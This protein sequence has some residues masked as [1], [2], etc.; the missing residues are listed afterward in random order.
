MRWTRQLPI[1]PRPSALTRK[2]PRRIGRGHAYW[3]EGE[4]DKAIS[5]YT[6]AIRLDPKAAKAYVGRGEA[7][8]SKGNFDCAIADCTEAIRLNPRDTAAYD[9]RGMAFARKQEFDKAIADCTE[10]IRLDPIDGRM[11]WDRGWVYPLKGDKSRAADDYAQAKKLGYPPSVLEPDAKLRDVN[12]GEPGERGPGIRVEVGRARKGMT[13]SMAMPDLSILPAAG[14]GSHRPVN[15]R[16]GLS[17]QSVLAATQYSVWSDTSAQ[18][19]ERALL[20]CK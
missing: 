2:M 14:R 16:C 5:N 13:N 4:F 17:G 12:N 10:A 9:G 6:E 18:L 3:N 1:A 7:H 8:W 15:M 19:I 20:S 11:F